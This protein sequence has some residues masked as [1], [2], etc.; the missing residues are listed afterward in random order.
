MFFGASAIGL[1]VEREIAAKLWFVAERVV[2]F[3]VSSCLFLEF[4]FDSGDIFVRVCGGRDRFRKLHI[5]MF[6]GYIK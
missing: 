6:N 1:L 4:F 2:L 3:R 5:M